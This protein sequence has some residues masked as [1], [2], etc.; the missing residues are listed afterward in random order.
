MEILR[1][2][3]FQACEPQHSLLLEFIQRCSSTD[4]VP[5]SGRCLSSGM[6]R[7]EGNVRDLL[8]VA[9]TCLQNSC[10]KHTQTGRLV[11][12]RSDTLICGKWRVCLTHSH[13]N[14]FLD[15]FS[16]NKAVG[17]FKALLCKR[18]SGGWRQGF[19]RRRFKLR[20]KLFCC[21]WLIFNILMTFLLA[22]VSLYIK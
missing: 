22:L 11:A 6:I 5:F 9:I 21:L 7:F 19:K 18:I 20:F 8:Q 2:S 3:C 14:I 4:T 13:I 10:S 12:P 1:C 17:G 16:A 15:G